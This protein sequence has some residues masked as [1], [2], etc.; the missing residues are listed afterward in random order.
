VPTITLVAAPKPGATAHDAQTDTTF[1]LGV[2]TFVDDPTIWER[3][4]GLQRFGY[5]FAVVDNAPPAN[6]APVA[7][8]AADTLAPD[9]APAQ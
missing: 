1:H 3:L 2:P 6:P 5:H 7:G 8:Q 9:P 4:T